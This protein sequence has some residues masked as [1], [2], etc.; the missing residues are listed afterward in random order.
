MINKKDTQEKI[1]LD[2]KYKELKNSNDFTNADVFQVSTYCLLHNVN[3]AILLYP[4]WDDEK[5]DTFYYLN[6]D[7]FDKNKNRYRIFFKTINLK[8][9]YLGDTKTLNNIKQDIKNILY[10]NNNTARNS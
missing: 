8:Y 4:Q 6:N 9:D 10:I 2:T 5:I 1:I 7:E 3:N